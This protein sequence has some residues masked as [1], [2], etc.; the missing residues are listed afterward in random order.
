MTKFEY[1]TVVF[2]TRSLIRAPEL[3]G[4]LFGKK[5]DEYGC[6]GWE[7]V[8]LVPLNRYSGDTSSVVAVF[9]RALAS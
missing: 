3:D 8:S 5:L 6:Q 9:K 2:D 4:D 7:L 1:A